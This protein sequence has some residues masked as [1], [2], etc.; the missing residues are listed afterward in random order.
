M[1]LLLFSYWNRFIQVEIW[2]VVRLCD[3]L[4]MIIMLMMLIG[5]RVRCDIISNV[6]N[7][8]Y[9]SFVHFNCIHHHWW[10]RLCQTHD[11]LIAYNPTSNIKMIQS[12]QIV[13]GYE[14]VTVINDRRWSKWCHDDDD[15]CTWC[16]IKRR[17]NDW[18]RI[19]RKMIMRKA[20]V[21]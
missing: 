13:R 17:N 1:K 14:A 3:R 7:R 5:V 8:L 18:S 9:R 21:L 19:R 16:Y 4:S 12:S 2:Y 20:N 11:H 15:D 6:Y 10:L